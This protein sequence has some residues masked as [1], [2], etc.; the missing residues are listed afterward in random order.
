ME[1]NIRYDVEGMS[2]QNGII[3]RSCIIPIEVETTYHKKPIVRLRSP[4]ELFFGFIPARYA[5]GIKPLDLRLVL[6]I[7]ITMVV[8]A[9]FTLNFNTIFA[10]VYMAVIVLKD[11]LEITYTSYQIKFGKCKSLGR[12]H[13]AEHMAIDAYL[14]Y[15]R[16]PT[17]E[18]IRKASRFQEN[19]GSRMVFR[20]LGFF[21][22]LSITFF[23]AGFVDLKFYIVEVVI[24][25]LIGILVSR[26]SI[27]KYLQV[28]I[29]NKPTDQELEVAI[30]GIKA[31]QE[32]EDDFGE[33]MDE[34][35]GGR[36]IIIM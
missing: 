34:M 14:K 27:G 4:L 12:Y 17:L 31:L 24:S 23:T 32:A 10:A 3:F 28:F 16:V 11:L 36:C 1:N 2:M 19:C 6:A 5:N 18:E 30:K 21:L 13:A 22:P 25:L 9:V 20:R 15:K 7:G 26:K 8:L 35:I 33:K 29:T